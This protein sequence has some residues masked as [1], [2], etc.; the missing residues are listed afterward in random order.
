M[1]RRFTRND[2]SKP[3]RPL[4]ERFADEDGCLFYVLSRETATGHAVVAVRESETYDVRRQVFKHPLQQKSVPLSSLPG[5]SVGCPCFLSW[6]ESS[7]SCAMEWEGVD[8]CGSV[9][10][11]LPCCTF[12]HLPGDVAALVTSMK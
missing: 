10:L 2:L 12:E 7:S 1:C 3:A 11:S 6:R 8:A 4:I 5:L 9:S